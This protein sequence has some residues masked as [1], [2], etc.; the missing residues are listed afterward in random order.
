MLAKF[1]KYIIEYYWRKVPESKRRVCIHK[2]SCSKTV[3]NT[4]NE[5]GFIEG[6]KIYFERRTTCNSSYIIDEIDGKIFIVTKNG[7][8]ISE[9]YI[10]PVIVK[11]YKSSL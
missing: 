9:D 1:G 3:Y 5:F 8:V 11:E 2:I 6:V 7:Q 4:F 10:N